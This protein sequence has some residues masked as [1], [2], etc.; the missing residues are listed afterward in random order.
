MTSLRILMCTAL[1]IFTISARAEDCA[2]RY[3]D[4]D[5]TET[6]KSLK[7]SLPKFKR[8]GFVNETK[9]SYFLITENDKGFNIVFFTTGLFDLYG[10]RR[11]GELKF[12]DKDSKISV[13][14]LGRTQ[15]VRVE[16]AKLIFD[17][18]K[19]RQIYTEGLMPEPLM[20]ANELT[21]Q[22]LDSEAK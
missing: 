18:G 8:K 6:L 12:C 14:G 10:I 15:A 3:S 1:T 7:E 13:I 16:G 2:D 21:Q 11:E 5:K 9:G 19:P 4:L 17:E 20:K 22:P